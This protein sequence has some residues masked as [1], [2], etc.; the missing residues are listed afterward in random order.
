MR[1]AADWSAL[2][3]RFS[4]LKR[5]ASRIIQAAAARVALQVP[6]HIAILNLPAFLNVTW[7]R[8]NEHVG[9]APK[10]S[11]NDV[12]QLET[13]EVKFPDLSSD[14]FHCSV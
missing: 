3:S 4:G 12:G 6:T 10:V 8:G 14:E 2:P 9:H 11:S 5:I 1:S 13:I 7:V